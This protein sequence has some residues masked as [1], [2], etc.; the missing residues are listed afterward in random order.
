MTAEITADGMPVP[1]TTSEGEREQQPRRRPRRKAIFLLVLLGLLATLTTIALWYFLF[2]QPVTALPLP[3]IPQ[4]EVPAYSTAVYGAQR[5]SGVAVSPSGDRIYVTQSEGSRVGLVFD[6]AGT[7][8]GTMAPPEAT[9]TDHAPVY[10]A[11]DPL[12]SEVYVSDRLTGAIYIYDRDGAYQRTFTL[13]AQRPGWQPLGLAFDSKGNLY[14]TDL[15]GPFQ[16]VLVIDRAAAV[17]RTLGENDKLSFP[18]GVA[19]DGTG[20]VYV[21]DSNN[22]RL[23]MY[24]ADGKVRAQ[25]GRGSGQGNLGLPR[26]LAVDGSGRVFVA[27]STGQGVFVYRAPAGDERRLQYLGYVGGEGVSDGMFEYPNSVAIDARGRVYVADTFNDRVQI[28][29]Y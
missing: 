2:R 13:A 17:V 18:N 9:G 27:D 15:S 16:K 21:S 29:S 20:N 28:W 1:P 26:G 25:I 7:K 11:V 6:A 14:V 19:V 4:V 24:G 8:L 22:G 10:A 5:P 3:G 12:T 23:L